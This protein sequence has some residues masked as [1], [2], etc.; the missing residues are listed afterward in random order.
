MWD[1]RGTANVTPSSARDIG[2]ISLRRP[3]DGGSTTAGIR[4]SPSR[5]SLHRVAAGKFGEPSS[6]RLINAGRDET[7]TDSV[8]GEELEERALFNN[9]R[10][11]VAAV[12]SL[13]KYINIPSVD[14]V[15]VVS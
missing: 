6:G 9:T 11:V 10:V 13:L 3:N 12:D 5:T 15:T 14:E 4:N 8:G 2:G 7:I 1:I